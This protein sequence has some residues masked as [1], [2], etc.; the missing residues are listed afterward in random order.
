MIDRQ[1]FLDPVKCTPLAGRQA[2]RAVLP[3]GA[4]RLRAA[5]P[6]IRDGSAPDALR[7]GFKGVGPWLNACNTW[8]MSAP[9]AL[10]LHWPPGSGAVRHCDSTADPDKPGDQQLP[11]S[12]NHTPC[13]R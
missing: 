5:R 1:R 3:D 12:G 4:D 10:R 7:H 9:P 6:L 11:L 2:H 8:D 13:A